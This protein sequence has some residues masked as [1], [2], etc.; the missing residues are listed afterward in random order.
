LTLPQAVRRS[1]SEGSDATNSAP[2]EVVRGYVE[3]QHEYALA[4]HDE[5]LVNQ[6][7]QKIIKPH[8]KT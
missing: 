1:F 4:K 5:A 3:A 6:Y 7:A 8:R 2:I